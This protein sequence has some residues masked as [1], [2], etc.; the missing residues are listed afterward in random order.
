[1]TKFYEYVWFIIDM[2]GGVF[3]K[4]AIYVDFFVDFTSI[5]TFSSVGSKLPLRLP[6]K[7]SVDISGYLVLNSNF[8]N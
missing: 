5:F 3:G 8:S 1:M 7:I 6:Q 4:I 2:G